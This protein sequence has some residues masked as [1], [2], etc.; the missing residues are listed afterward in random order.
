[1]PGVHVA[2]GTVLEFL[3]AEQDLLVVLLAVGPVLL[4]MY[5]VAACALQRLHG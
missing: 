5:A 3:T 4:V 2:N 1:M